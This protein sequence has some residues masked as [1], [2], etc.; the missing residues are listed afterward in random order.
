MAHEAVNTVKL[1]L[2]YVKRVLIGLDQ[3][4]NT[5]IGGAPDETISARAGRL[6]HRHGWKQLA[7]AL[8]K[9]DR[10]H[11]E[12]AIKSER[13][14]RQQDPAYDDVYDPDDVVSVVVTVEKK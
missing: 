8:N 12:D 3:F 14:G 4:G 1:F 2:G 6:R 9:I 7:W 11:V 10:N 5:L 13:T